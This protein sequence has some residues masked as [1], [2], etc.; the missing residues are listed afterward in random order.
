M[1]KDSAFSENVVHHTL[2]KILF[3]RKH[4]SGP[5]MAAADMD[6]VSTQLYAPQCLVDT[7][8][9]DLYGVFKG[10]VDEISVGERS[11]SFLNAVFEHFDV[12]CGGGNFV[13]LHID[14]SAVLSGTAGS[15]CLR[16]IV[17]VEMILQ[18]DEGDVGVGGLALC[19]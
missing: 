6:A 16:G 9:V 14:G 5:A 1:T 11:A 7:S 3:L 8:F 4:D 2:A 10:S 13:R 15:N 19:S 17:G 18:D 12:P